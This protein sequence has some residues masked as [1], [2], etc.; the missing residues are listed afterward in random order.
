MAYRYVLTWSTAL[1]RFLYCLIGQFN[2]TVSPLT[3]LMAW[4]GEGES[5]LPRTSPKRSATTTS[6]TLLL[7][8]LELLSL[9]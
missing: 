5:L 6:N 8:N 3:G 4:V 9:R 7:V 2:V 1:L